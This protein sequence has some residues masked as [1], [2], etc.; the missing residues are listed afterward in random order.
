MQQRARSQSEFASGSPGALAPAT[1]A[2]AAQPEIRTVIKEVRVPSPPEIRTV[3]REVPSPPEIRTVIKEVRVPSPPEI[4]TVI[5]EVRVPVPCNCTGP[6]G[7]SRVPGHP[8]VT[9][10][11]FNRF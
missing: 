8:P 5:K 10:P 6:T 1:D 11:R 3:V 4:R 7:P 9:R 2:L